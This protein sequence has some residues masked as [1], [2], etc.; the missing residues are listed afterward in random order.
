[1]WDVMAQ[2]GLVRER[3]CAAQVD[4]VS[5]NGTEASVMAAMAAAVVDVEN[6]RCS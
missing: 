6:K 4:L 2:I 3:H 1:M 5:R